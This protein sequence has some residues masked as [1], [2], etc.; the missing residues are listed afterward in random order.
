MLEANEEGWKVPF[1]TVERNLQLVSSFCFYMCPLTYIVRAH[2]IHIGVQLL[3][4]NSLLLVTTGYWTK[5]LAKTHILLPRHLV[6][7]NFHTPLF[8]H[9]SL[10]YY[11]YLMN[12][13]FKTKILS[14]GFIYM[15]K[16]T[17]IHLYLN[18][19]TS[20]CVRRVIMV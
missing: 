4:G 13:L 5:V 6:Q 11:W 17:A 12:A 1:Y 2:Y 7:Q 18:M 10:L 9:V 3:I 8:L 19:Y 20:L 16:G 14:E 15:L